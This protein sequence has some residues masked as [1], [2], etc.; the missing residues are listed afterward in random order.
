[1][2]E[3]NE[4]CVANIG[5]HNSETGET[6]GNVEAIIYKQHKNYSIKRLNMKIWQEGLDAVMN[7]VIS[8]NLD[9]KL[10]NYIKALMDKNGQILINQTQLAEEFNV[11]RNKIATFIR[12]L[13]DEQFIHKVQ[14]GVYIINPFIIRPK[15]MTNEDCENAQG[16]WETIYGI[17][18]RN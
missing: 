1:M 9:T 4:S 14:N 17:P 8:S 3:T 10:F 2:R 18:E 13:V 12:K 7:S 11:K 5:L 15:G 16:Y 6:I